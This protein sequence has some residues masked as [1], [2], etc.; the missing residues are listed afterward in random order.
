MGDGEDGELFFVDAPPRPSVQAPPS[1]EAQAP[2]APGIAPLE[3]DDEADEE[4]DA[5]ADEEA[6]EAPAEPPDDGAAEEED[7]V[8][9]APG[10]EDRQLR[11]SEGSTSA[12]RPSM[13]LR[14]MCYDPFQA[15][16]AVA[17]ATRRRLPPASDKALSPGAHGRAHGRLLP[18]L[19]LG[20]RPTDGPCEFPELLASRG[21]PPASAR[22][23]GAGADA[24]TRARRR[25][26]SASGD[27]RDAATAS[28]CIDSARRLRGLWGGRFA[29]FAA[30]REMGEALE[31]ADGAGDGDA[32]LA[33]GS[34]EIV[35]LCL[36][37]P[38]AVGARPPGEPGAAARAA[39][40][41]LRPCR[42]AALRHCAW[43]DRCSPAKPLSDRSGYSQVSTDDAASWWT[44]SVMSSSAT[45]DNGSIDFDHWAGPPVSGSGRRRRRSPGAALA[46]LPPPE[47]GVPGDAA[48]ATGE[49]ESPTGIFSAAP[50]L[51]DPLQG[52][53]GFGWGPVAGLALPLG[54]SAKAGPPQG[55]SA[56]LP[57]VQR[58]PRRSAR[59]R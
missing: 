23:R 51:F 42:E 44:S 55:A 2:W 48:A 52:A 21:A 28:A 27:A 11:V 3:E 10:A 16:D 47:A 54:A 17:H 43:S 32:G 50:H 39:A 13:E 1:L 18:P 9:E 34:A 49:A 57:P 20:G 33:A 14:C 45:A 25:R 6:A 53:E 12:G 46:V 59:A 19:R 8:A 29:A 56:S 24:A 30:S 58:P 26:R 22:G 37:L 5:E 15:T 40:R 38:D 41:C 35:A 31:E 7:G 4:E 36:R